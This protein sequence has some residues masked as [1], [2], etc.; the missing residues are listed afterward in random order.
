MLGHLSPLCFVFLFPGVSNLWMMQTFF[1]VLFLCCHDAGDATGDA[2]CR[3]LCSTCCTT[4]RTPS[5]TVDS[6]LFPNDH[7][8][9]D[10]V[11]LPRM[12]VVPEEGAFFHRG[13]GSGSH[14]GSGSASETCRVWELLLHPSLLPDRR[15]ESV[16]SRSG[17]SRKTLTSSGTWTS[18]V[19]N[20]VRYVWSKG[21]EGRTGHGIENGIDWEKRSKTWIW[22]WSEN[23]ESG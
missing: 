20:C 6:A 17:D 3:S 11:P 9:Q 5:P 13:C 15:E 4:L 7:D 18:S 16:A 8:L 14:Q 12:V 1:P 2:G 10:Y 21:N 19:H 23:T 22:I